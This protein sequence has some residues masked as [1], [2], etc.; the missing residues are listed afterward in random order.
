MCA[1][2]C[3]YLM[4]VNQ[5]KKK[6]APVPLLRPILCR[7]S[8]VWFRDFLRKGVRIREGQF[9]GEGSFPISLPSREGFDLSAARSK[10]LAG[11]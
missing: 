3:V 4:R 5:V 9:A 8:G 7:H 6:S 11:Y 2:A 1:Y 10:A